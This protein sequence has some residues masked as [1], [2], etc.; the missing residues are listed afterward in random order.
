MANLLRRRLRCCRVVKRIGLGSNHAGHG[1]DGHDWQP[2]TCWTAG[3]D[4]KFRKHEDI[5]SIKS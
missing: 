4:S 5:L 3:T 1:R 2:S